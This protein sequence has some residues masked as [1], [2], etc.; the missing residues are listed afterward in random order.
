MPQEMLSERNRAV[1]DHAAPSTGGTTAGTPS[2]ATAGATGMFR[3]AL[4]G[5]TAAVTLVAS[6]LAASIVVGCAK[7]AP[8]GF[9]IA[10]GDATSQAGGAAARGEPVPKGQSAEGSPIASRGGLYAYYYRHRDGDKA[11]YRVSGNARR[12]RKL[13]VSYR[14]RG[15]RLPDDQRAVVLMVRRDYGDDSP[16][17]TYLLEDETSGTTRALGRQDPG[18]EVIIFF[19]PPPVT[20]PW[21]KAARKGLEMEIPYRPVIVEGDG[22]KSAGEMT[23][24]RFEVLGREGL[25]VRDATGTPVPYRT[26]LKWRITD[27]DG[28]V[29][30]QWFGRIGEVVRQDI[31][32]P[33]RKW[34]RQEL[35]R[36]IR[37]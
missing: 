13:T 29:R 2:G 23:V 37:R 20:I 33:N 6:M 15:L 14:Y 19:D 18:S 8:P 31:T 3:V 25:R 30:M 10:A 11:V 4:T 24:Q 5:L 7:P 32:Y 16:D 27:A 28:T 21:E 1:R 9:E 36:L 12:S 35:I 34:E 26:C 22:V 17:T